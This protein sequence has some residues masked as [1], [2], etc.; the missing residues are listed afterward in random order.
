MKETCQPKL[1]TK[2]QFHFINILERQER[3]LFFYQR[4]EVV[5]VLFF[6]LLKRWRQSKLRCLHS[7]LC[8]AFLKIARERKVFVL[9][10]PHSLRDS[11]GPASFH[12]NEIGRGDRKRQTHAGGSG[13]PLNT[14]SRVTGGDRVTEQR[15]GLVT[16]SEP[17]RGRDAGRP[18]GRAF[19]FS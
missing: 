11:S 2:V 6:S 17:A 9:T 16:P 19:R 13:K 5:V 3:D 15:R 7:S 1:K 4:S 14:R 8:R 18:T 12:S 10:H